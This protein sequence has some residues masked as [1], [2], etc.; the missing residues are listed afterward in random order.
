MKAQVALKKDKFD[1][2]NLLVTSLSKAE[3]N[4]HVKLRLAMS[5]VEQLLLNSQAAPTQS[6]PKNQFIDTFDL[7][8][9]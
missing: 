2:A 4:F 8:K 6:S 7:M 1:I 3:L 9:N 5:K